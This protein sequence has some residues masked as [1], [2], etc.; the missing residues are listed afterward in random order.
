MNW[1]FIFKPSRCCSSV[2]ITTRTKTT[3]ARYVASRARDPTFEKLMEKYKNLLKVVAIQDLFLASSNPSSSISL[4]FLNRLSQK[5]RLNRGAASFLRKYP[6]IFQIFYDTNKSQ[7]FLQINQRCHYN[8]LGNDFEDSVISRNSNL[9]RHC[10]GHEPNTHILKLADV[11]PEKSHLTAA[12]ENW[13]V[14]ECCREDSHVDRTEIRFSFKHG[15]P[16]AI[17]LSKD[18][19]AK[20]QEWQR[21]PYVGSYERIREKRKSKAAIM[22]LEK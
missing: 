7:S 5:L 4:D 6:H 9:F 17:R 22:V 12:V 21:L 16:P 15:F 1:R 13:R 18:W 10:D 8:C 19:K 14:I 11:V 20:A 3:S 2:V